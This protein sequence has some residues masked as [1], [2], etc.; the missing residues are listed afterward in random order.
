MFQEHRVADHIS[1]QA[2]PG[3]FVQGD[4][5]PGEIRGAFR[6]KIRYGLPAITAMRTL[7]CRNIVLD[8][9]KHRMMPA[10]V[11]IEFL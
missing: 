8:L 6:I 7:S 5:E 4:Q 11:Q 9:Q 1:E 2:A 3:A 10:L